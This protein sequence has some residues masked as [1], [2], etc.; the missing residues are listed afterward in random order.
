VESCR[1]AR[2]VHDLIPVARSGLQAGE[3]TFADVAKPLLDYLD[4]FDP[5]AEQQLKVVC[6][7][8]GSPNR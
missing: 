7:E 2:V 3:T 4:Q 6:V 5:F 8:P 1:L